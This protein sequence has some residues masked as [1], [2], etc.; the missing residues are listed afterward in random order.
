MFLGQ[1]V[2]VEEHVLERRVDAAL[3]P[4]RGARHRAGGREFGFEEREQLALCVLSNF[5]GPFR[6]FF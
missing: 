1:P 2:V 4:V 6:R 3:Q 5:C